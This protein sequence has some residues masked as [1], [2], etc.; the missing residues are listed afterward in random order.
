MAGAAVNL[1]PVSIQDAKRFV[2]EH[3]RHCQ[4]PLS[5]RFAIGLAI[6]D[7]L[8]GVAIVGRPVARAIEHVFTAE[9]TRLCVRDDAPRNAC[10]MLYG[11]CWRAWKAMG[12]RR[13]ITYTLQSE[14][15]ASLRGAGFIVVGEVSGGQWSREGRPRDKRSIYDQPKFRWEPSA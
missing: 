1:V 15:G 6:E 2:T 13:L 8:V 4:A 14:S 11:A 3:H 7:D 9:I 12:G 10:S 5:G